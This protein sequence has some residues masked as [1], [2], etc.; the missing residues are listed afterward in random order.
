MR[1]FVDRTGTAWHHSGKEV[2]AAGWRANLERDE[3]AVCGPVRLEILY[4]AKSADDYTAIAEELD[5]LHQLPCDQAHWDRALDVQHALAQRGGLH[6]RSVKLV[7]LMIAAIAERADA[8]VW[9][10]DSDY[11]RVAEITGQ[12]T[13]L[14]DPGGQHLAPAATDT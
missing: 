11:D 4:S 9:H 10:Y 6:H 5:A 1:R 3:I 8:T 2:I 12:R 13:S 14:I 7:D